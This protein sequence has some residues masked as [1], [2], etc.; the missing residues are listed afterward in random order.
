VRDRSAPDAIAPVVSRRSH[1]GESH[2]VI[3]G[4][5]ARSWAGAG[6]SPAVGALVLHGFTGS[7]STMRS[8]AEVLAAEGHAVE[9]PRLPGHGTHVDDMM[10]TGW[11][12]WSAEALRAHD[13]LAARVERVVVVGLSM[14]ATL[15]AAVAIERP[16][17][18]ALVVINGALEPLGDDLAQAVRDALSA[19]E[20]LIP[21]EGNDIA[22][23]GVED[24]S[25]DGT[26]LRPLLSL[27]EAGPGLAERLA[28]ITCPTLVMSAP[29][30]HVVAPSASRYFADRVRARVEWVDLP[31]S[32]HVAT[33]DHD[34]VL[35]EERVAAFVA[36]VAGR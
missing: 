36:R 24:L 4:A 8:L 20:T 33:L 17:V 6:A 29:Q 32:F 22:L 31:N 21:S 30:D 9:L 16:S 15:A 5:E 7:P 18:A 19:G 13:E 14:G 34:R 1:P 26:P 11:P 2:P 27:V 3:V 25:Y 23:E 35:I 12:D 10:A 28:E